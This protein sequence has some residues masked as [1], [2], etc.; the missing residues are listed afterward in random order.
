MC[1]LDYVYGAVPCPGRNKSPVK[2]LILCCND[3]T[4]L[5][6]ELPIPPSVLAHQNVLLNKKRLGLPSLVIPDHDITI[7]LHMDI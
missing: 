3:R 6:V 4:V 2:S 5:G 7:N 1:E